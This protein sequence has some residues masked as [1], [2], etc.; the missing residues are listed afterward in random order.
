MIDYIVACNVQAKINLENL[1][2]PINLVYQFFSMKKSE[3]LSN[4]Y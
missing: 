4:F 1:Y 3:I 2:F